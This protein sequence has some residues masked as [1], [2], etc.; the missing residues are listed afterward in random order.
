MQDR[1]FKKAFPSKNAKSLKFIA[2]K[3]EGFQK[4]GKRF[5]K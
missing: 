5:K 1:K 3:G 4:V 2:D